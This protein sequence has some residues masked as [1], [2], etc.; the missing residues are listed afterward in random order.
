MCSSWCVEMWH[1]V[2]LFVRVLAMWLF[3]I[4][5]EIEF[6]LWYSLGQRRF[7]FMR[8]SRDLSWQGSSANLNMWLSFQDLRQL[9]PSSSTFHITREGS[10]QISLF[11]REFTW[12]SE[13]YFFTLLFCV[14]LSHVVTPN[15]QSGWKKCGVYQSLLKHSVASWN[16]DLKAK[17]NE[18][19]TDLMFLPQQERYNT[20]KKVTGTG[21]L[22]CLVWITNT[23]FIFHNKS[24]HRVP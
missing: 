24:R 21:H 20:E 13:F 23:S 16:S 3:Q 2:S 17:I 7:C 9:F 15:G 11:L 6:V 10:Q 4:V 5:P 12:T 18:L 1:W 8:L 19:R 14:K 22:E